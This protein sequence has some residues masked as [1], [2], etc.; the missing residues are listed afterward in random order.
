MLYFFYR[1]V[2]DCFN[3]NYI[4][5][6][7]GPKGNYMGVKVILSVS[8]IQCGEKKNSERKHKHNRDPGLIFFVKK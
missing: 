5:F 2:W 4:N 3:S 1:V 7:L 8:R 6:L